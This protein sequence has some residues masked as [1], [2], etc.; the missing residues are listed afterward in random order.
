M[1]VPYRCPNNNL[2]IL[3]A[4]S[5]S[6]CHGEATAWPTGPREQ[7][8]DPGVQVELDLGRVEGD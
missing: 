1:W 5:L 6:R 2:P 7:I 4:Y 8:P 3:N